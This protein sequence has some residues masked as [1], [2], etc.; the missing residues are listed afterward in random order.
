MLLLGGSLHIIVFT[1]IIVA[2]QGIDENVTWLF[3]PSEANVYTADPIARVFGGRLYIY[4]SWDSNTTCGPAGTGTA[5]G[6][7]QFCMSGYRAYSTSDP[8]LRRGWQLHGAVLNENSVPWV[9]HGDTAWVAS[10][11][12][13]APEVI[14]GDDGRYYLFF[15]APYRNM[16][17][18]RIGVAVS[19]SPAGPFI[20]R[21]QPIQGTFGIDPSVV[22]LETRSWVLFES[23]G[24]ELWVS[25]L[26]AQFTSATSR[27]QLSGLKQGYKEGPH[28]EMSNSTLQL[29]YSYSTSGSYTI[30]QAEANDA[31]HPEWGFTQ[32]STTIAKF[33]GR[34]NHAS[35]V[36]YR[37]KRWVMYHRHVEVQRERWATRRVLIS[38]VQSDKF[39]RA[40]TIKPYYHNHKFFVTLPPFV[41]VCND[42]SVG[43]AHRKKQCCTKFTPKCQFMGQC[44]RCTTLLPPAL[45]RLQYQ[46]SES[47]SPSTSSF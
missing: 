26:N 24:G 47:V 21:S 10:A 4:T 32:V 29:Y 46:L 15:P 6:Y 39:G 1:T 2:A 13:W 33:D 42:C 30:E 16:D 9:Y 34:T 38:P 41:D 5:Q 18:M 25:R 3:L 8:K 36:W 28:V 35:L 43:D 14:Q 37:S 12:M 20:A 44:Y 23:G 11:R 19:S 22:R 45:K 31:A 40:Y 7:Q 27:V 17:D